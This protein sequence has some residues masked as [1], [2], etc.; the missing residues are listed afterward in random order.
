MPLSSCVRCKK[1]FNKTDVP[2]C[3]D[4]LPEE[5][6]DR[7]KVEELVA[8]DSSLTV[9]QVSKM[10]EVDVSVVSR[11]MKEGAVATVAAGSVTCGRCGAPAISTT[12]RLC[13][14]CLDKLNAEVFQAQAEINS[15]KSS[16][17]KRGGNVRSE[18]D[19]KRRI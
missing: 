4:C 10:A 16:V 3:A 18:F 12:K 2:V 1:I 9:E 8:S 15:T 7:K 17:Q 13:Q 19:Q 6:A 14:S 5:Q 11:M